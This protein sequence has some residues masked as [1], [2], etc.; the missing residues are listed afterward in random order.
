[1]AIVRQSDNETGE[2]STSLGSVP[3][4]NKNRQVLHMRVLSASLMYIASRTVVMFM[5]RFISYGFPLSCMPM[6][7]P[8]SILS[9][10]TNLCQP[11]T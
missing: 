2:V 5:H 11:S 3:V 10:S 7:V 1:M 9:C 8:H 6:H 4:R